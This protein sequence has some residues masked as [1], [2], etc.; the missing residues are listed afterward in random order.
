MRCKTMSRE[1]SVVYLASECYAERI[2]L[3]FPSDA[4]TVGRDQLLHNGL[5]A[6]LSSSKPTSLY[7]FARCSESEMVKT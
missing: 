2:R 6:F 1:I 3:S 4:T 5:Y 7:V